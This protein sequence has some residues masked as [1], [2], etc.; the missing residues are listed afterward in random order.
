MKRVSSFTAKGLD[1]SNHITSLVFNSERTKA[2][3]FDIGLFND[4]DCVNQNIVEHSIS[5][6]YDERMLRDKNG[7]PLDIATFEYEGQTYWMF[8]ID[9]LLLSR[10]YEFENVK[11][12]IFGYINGIVHHTD[13]NIRNLSE[14]KV[15]YKIWAKYCITY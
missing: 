3:G 1:E 9:Y 14:D 7:N 15:L 11:S 2:M 12:V 5:M 4:D 8:Y 6:T 10:L 13:T